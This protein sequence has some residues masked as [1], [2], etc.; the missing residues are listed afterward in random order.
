MG[1]VVKLYSFADVDRSG[2]VRWTAAELGLEVEECR[3]KPG[4]HRRPPYTD[5]NPFGQIPSAEFQG[6]TLLEST[7]ICFALSDAV[8]EP[9]LQIDRG[10]PGRQAFVYWMAVFTE[11]HEARLVECAV[12]RAGILGPEYFDLHQRALKRKLGVVAD[13]LPQE[14]WLCGEQF[15]L[16]DICAGYS[17][18]LAVQS[19]LLT[20]DDVNPYFARLRSRPAAVASRI[21]AS[22]KD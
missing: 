10:E 5:M 11:T 20:I 1:D 15:T 17:L 8:A 7:A 12:S 13:Q 22:L 3:V 16:A 21:F 14:G 6:Q 4:E 19:G 9:K 2:K 18:R